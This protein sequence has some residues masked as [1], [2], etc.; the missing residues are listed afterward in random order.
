MDPPP[1]LPGGGREHIDECGEV[2]V[3]DTPRSLERPR[4]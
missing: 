1:S 3:G 2:V 4:R